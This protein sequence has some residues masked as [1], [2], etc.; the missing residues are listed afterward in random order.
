MELDEIRQRY[1]E[2]YRLRPF[3]G[4]L[5]PNYTII[6][7]IAK[8][9]CRGGMV[10]DVGCGSGALSFLNAGQAKKVI[11]FD[12]SRQ[13][14]ENARKIQKML[15]IKNISFGAGDAQDIK[16]PDETFDV[17]LHSE[18][19]E[20]LQE[21]EAALREAARVVRRHGYLIL[22][23]PNECNPKGC[24]KRILG[25]L[26]MKMTLQPMDSP[27]KPSELLRIAKDSGLEA[28][29]IVGFN[30]GDAW[31]LTGNRGFIAKIIMEMPEGLKRHL[32]RAPKAMQTLI[33]PELGLNEISMRNIREHLRGDRVG[34]LPEYPLS[35]L[36]MNMV[37]VFRKK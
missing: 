32:R 20:H 15:G 24:V 29:K 31:L 37:Y 35:M 7:K 17:V 1:D 9:L 2:L 34:F 4:N 12:I 18:V 10:L 26:G 11:A 16:F 21:P 3:F 8:P 33:F 6:T 27:L 13:A 22:S 19:L 23:T 30:F 14:I 28:E 25:K 36:A 5:R